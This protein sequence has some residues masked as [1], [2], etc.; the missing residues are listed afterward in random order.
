MI[1]I[2]DIFTGNRNNLMFNKTNFA[3]RHITSLINNRLAN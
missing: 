3:L 2:L 1:I